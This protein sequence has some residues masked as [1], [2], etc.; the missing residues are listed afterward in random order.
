[1]LLSDCTLMSAR[2]AIVTVAVSG[3]S[4][5]GGDDGSANVVYSFTIPPPAASQSSGSLDGGADAGSPA[6]S[7]LVY[8]FAGSYD[9]VGN[10]T[11]YTDSVMGQW[12]FSY[13]R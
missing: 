4:M 8:H 3:A 5:T 7:T 11:G 1:M 13:D 6:Q 2:R 10:L 12:S 9:G